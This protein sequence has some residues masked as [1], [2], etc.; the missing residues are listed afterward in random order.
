MEKRYAFRPGVMLTLALVCAGLILGLCAPAGRAAET[1]AP[2]ASVTTDAPLELPIREN[3][4]AAA[5]RTA[6]SDEFYVI[7]ADGTLIE[8]GDYAGYGARD[9]G[10]GFTFNRTWEVMGNVAAV[11]A[12]E[13]S[14]VLAVDREGTLW[15]VEGAVEG[16]WIKS[17]LPD[18]TWNDTVWPVKLLENVAMASADRHHAVILKRDGTLWVAGRDT[19]GAPWLD[20]EGSEELYFLQVMD[21]VIWADTT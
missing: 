7:R 16:R 9:T 20:K 5:G 18:F 6:D 2:Q 21:N 19:Y 4:V 15:L 14:V 13:E 10:D 3:P 12:S 11:Y 1:E 17:L 8:S